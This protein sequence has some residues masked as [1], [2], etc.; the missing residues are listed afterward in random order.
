VIVKIFLFISLSIYLILSYVSVSTFN[1]ENYIN[2]EIRGEIK[3]EKILKLKLGSTLNYAL[4]DIVL[5]DS[6]DISSLSLNEKLSN[7]EIIVIGK[8]SESRKISINSG[9]YEELITLPGI[10]KTT[11][12]NI[13]NYRKENGSFCNLE[14]LKNVKGIGDK[15]FDKLKEFISL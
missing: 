7:N 6:A 5:L 8:K 15:T 9:T 3:E 14:D 1:S 4:K 11:A 10:G 12:L 2:V 13:I